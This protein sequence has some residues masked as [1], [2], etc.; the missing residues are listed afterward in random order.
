MSEDYR[1]TGDPGT[2]NRGLAQ[3]RG[4]FQVPA[5][6]QKR[7]A[8]KY[9][10]QS[11]PATETPKQAAKV[12]LVPVWRPHRIPD[13]PQVDYVLEVEMPQLVQNRSVPSGDAKPPISRPQK[14]SPAKSAREPQRIALPEVRIEG[15]RP[16]VSEK[17]DARHITL[18]EVRIG[19]SLPHSS[20]KSLVA[21]PEV[22]REVSSQRTASIPEV[23]IEVDKTADELAGTATGLAQIGVGLVY[24]LQFPERIKEEILEQ[25]DWLVSYAGNP[26]SAALL[27]MQALNPGSYLVRHYVE[28][29][30]AEKEGN[31]L[32]AA[33]NAVLMVGD[34]FSLAS[35]LPRRG[36]PVS[37]GELVSEQKGAIGSRST[38]PSVRMS[39]RAV[40][41]EE[42]EAATSSKA[43]FSKTAE[44]LPKQKPQAAGNRP[45]KPMLEPGRQL[46]N[47]YIAALK[48]RYPRLKSVDIRPKLRARVGRYEGAPESSFEERM[49][50]TQGNYSLVVYRKTT[51]PPIK[52]L[53]A[54]EF[55]GISVDGWIEEI[56]IEQRAYKVD[57]IVAQLRRAADFA[58]AYGL[59]GVRYSIAAP[60]VADLVEEEAARIP[61]VYRVP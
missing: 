21:V 45:T 35:L 49:Q 51:T 36:G 6:V 47:R 11:E 44:Q 12:G 31:R 32:D 4:V 8:E 40:V 33:R 56:K 19:T 20:Q 18:P 15:Q 43:P 30:Q 55:D 59:K 27:A 17:P 24:A 13:S 25:A 3:R 61:G 38:A 46:E 7:L 1:G 54:I 37:I 48:E 34:L 29:K 42:G 16:R 60:D 58:E 52:T 22:R 9:E 2:D 23:R 10:E 26:I 14:P 41:E 53:P 50:T 5:E 28:M 57:D 39:P